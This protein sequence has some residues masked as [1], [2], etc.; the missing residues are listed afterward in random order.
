MKTQPK[1]I[2]LLY[3]D[4]YYL[5]KQVYPFGLDLI[6]GYLRG[7]GYDVIVDY[8]FLPGPDLETNL[9]NILEQTNPQFIGLGIRNVDT[10]MS[11]ETYG[12]YGGN[13][14][15]TFYFLPEVK[16]IVDNIK[17]CAPKS[18]IIAGGG[19]FTISPAEILKYLG[20]RF[21]I[22]GEGEE[23][24]RRL[25]EA[26]PDMGKISK[27]P[28]LAYFDGKYLLNP[29]QNYRFARNPGYLGR[30]NAFN[31]AF[32][33]TGLP[34]QVKRGCNQ[35]C[36]CCVEPIIEGE[37]FVLRDIDCIIEELKITSQTYEGIRTIYFVDTEFNLPDLAYCTRLV[38][39]LIKEELHH[40]FSFSSQFLPRPFNRDFAKILAEAG[41]SIILTCDSFANDILEK[42][43]TSYRNRDI[44]SA[45]E[46]CEEHGISCTISMIFGLPGETYETLDHSLEQM[47]R[48]AP[49]FLR[50][51][52]YTIGGRIYQGTNLCGFAEK[53]KE[54]QHLYG[55][56]SDGYLEPFY[57]CSPESPMKLKQYI[58]GALGYPVAY[59]NR[60]DET[61]SNG[62]GIAYLADQGSWEEAISRFLK[63]NISAQSS[64][65]EYLFRKL[66][67]KGRVD[68]AR[69]IS[70][71]LL[72]AIYE[73]GK[74]APYRDQIE[75][76]QFYLS[77][78]G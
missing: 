56:K 39:R 53:G 10:C 72:E 16:K 24:L 42:N 70:K 55:V 61:I 69:A 63:S 67:E 9:K 6:A 51:Y 28:N 22:V 76:I 8:P 32:E 31:Y 54:K 5:I 58:E 62:L 52:E 27:I 34:V 60:Y 75:L 65:Y 2:L 18:P 45:L 43:W 77:C 40:R 26:F 1:R 59:E 12:D 7:Y 30:D 14:Y 46:L 25:I 48:Y 21:G 33:K 66:S 29:R 17:K 38:K 37:R 64:I 41:F 3:T 73:N 11:C 36:S 23:P 4:K 13:G 57:Y 47:K 78:L 50:R 71:N 68:D 74:T 19:G 20:L 44:I 35:R 15:R 49:N